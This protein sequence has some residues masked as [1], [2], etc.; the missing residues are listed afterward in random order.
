MV[1]GWAGVGEGKPEGRRGGEDRS[2][3]GGRAGVG[4][5]RG[6]VVWAQRLPPPPARAPLS[7]PLP[8]CSSSPSFPPSHIVRRPLPTLT[9]PLRPP[10][11]TC[12]E[13]PPD[14]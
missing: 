4:V 5:G 11:H 6:G 1:R 7:T 13:K 9:P 10:A 8:P 14:G 3:A 12:P 2:R